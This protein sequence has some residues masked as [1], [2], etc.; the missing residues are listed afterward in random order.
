ME[1][2]AGSPICVI[3]AKL[4][5]TEYDLVGIRHLC[6]CTFIT[7]I[8]T[9]KRFVKGC[10]IWINNVLSLCC[11]VIMHGTLMTSLKVALTIKKG[12]EVVSYLF[13][14]WSQLLSGYLA[15]YSRRSSNYWKTYSNLEDFGFQVGNNQLLLLTTKTSIIYRIEDMTR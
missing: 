13:M 7:G 5:E 6:L 2:E 12:A 11:M 8:S 1:C 15:I 14:S 10:K 9:I 4:L 3:W